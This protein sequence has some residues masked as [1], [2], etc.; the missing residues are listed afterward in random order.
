VPMILRMAFSLGL[1][2]QD[3]VPVRDNSKRGRSFVHTRDDR[4]WMG[5]AR[6]CVTFFFANN[7][8]QLELRSAGI[9]NQMCGR[10]IQVFRIAH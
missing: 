7:S 8:D 3:F 1:P 4:E 6:T 5:A 9:Q 10:A 2:R